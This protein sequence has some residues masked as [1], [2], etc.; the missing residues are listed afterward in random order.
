MSF[1][2][3]VLDLDGTVYRSGNCRDRFGE[4]VTF[5]SHNEHRNVVPIG[6]GL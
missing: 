2:G 4:F 1:A 5:V 6:V 3:T